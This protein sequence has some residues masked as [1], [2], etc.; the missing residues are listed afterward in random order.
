MKFLTPFLV[1]LALTLPGVALAAP[2]PLLSGDFS[3]VPEACRACPCGL[4]GALQLGQNLINVAVSLSIII[5]VLLIAY[6]G[7][8]FLFGAASPEA[9][10]QG[11]KLITNAVIGFV[12]VLSSWLVIDFIMK[13]VY[14]GETT[15]WGPWNEILAGGGIGMCLQE[16]DINALYDKPTGELSTVKAMDCTNCSSISERSIACKSPSSCTAKP[17]VVNMLV[18]LDEQFT[19]NWIVTEAFPPTV[20][21][22]NVC[23]ANATCVDAAFRGSTSYSEANVQA[24]MNAAKRAGFKPVYE[25]DSCSLKAALIKAGYSA[26]CKSDPGYGHITGTHF[27]LYGN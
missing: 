18:S 9:R 27:S 15:G 7:A 12:I 8:L 17:S 5:L 4:A 1:A 16:V 23:H 22:T 20:K 25:S 26:Y 14:D 19:G 11:K 2:L 13:A 3:I 24:F 6:A 21:H 10:S